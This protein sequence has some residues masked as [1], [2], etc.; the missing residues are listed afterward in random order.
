MATRAR[1]NADGAR[2]DA[3][4]ASPVLVTPN[5]GT[6]SA[7]VMTNMT[8]AVT[9]SLVDDAVTLD[10]MASGTDGNIISYDASGNPV[11]IVTGDDGQVLTST[12]AGSPPAF[13]NASGGL[14]SGSAI[15]EDRKAYGTHGGT[16]TSGAWRTRTLNT[17]VSD[18]ENFI[19]KHSDNLGFYVTSAGTY[20]FNFSCVM[21]H[22]NVAQAQ[23]LDVTTST[24]YRGLMLQADNHGGWIGGS[25]TIPS[26]AQNTTFRLQVRV[27]TT[28]TNASALGYSYWPDSYTGIPIYSHVTIL[29]HA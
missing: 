28:T 1:E 3:P 6:P 5:L 26:V 14:Y 9:A 7:G 19:T 11:A 25:C 4:L 17:V 20:T 16:I 10:K 15:I 21:A 12:G 29:K 24:E 18:I 22:C 23:I 2:L 8:G 13:E 27:Q